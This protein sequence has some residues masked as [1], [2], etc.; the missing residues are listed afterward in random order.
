MVQSLFKTGVAAH[1]VG[2]PANTLRV[3]ERRYGLQCQQQDEHGHRLY[4]PEDVQRIAALRQLT[5]QGHAI[6]ALAGL[7]QEEL[8][9]LLSTQDEVREVAQALAQP[10]RPAR[11]L[12]LVGAA[13]ATRIRRAAPRRQLRI[14][15]TVDT[16]AQARLPEG[17]GR[18][19][20]LVLHLPSMHVTQVEELAA[21]ARA[22][23]VARV[24]AVYGYSNSQA[25]R[26]CTELDIQPWRDTHNDRSLVSWLQDSL[27]ATSPGPAAAR[28]SPAAPSPA[29]LLP[30]RIAPPQYDEAT[31][32][33]WAAR[34]TAVACE[35]PAHVAE[36]L[37]RLQQFEA[38]SADCEHRDDADRQLHEQLHHLAGTARM[39]FE[40]GLQLLADHEQALARPPAH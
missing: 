8:R 7:N 32:A 18:P 30:A 25:L 20:A 13:L 10:V 11:Q 3:W 14:T 23:G 6:G 38:Y 2:M 21:A 33:D 12:L 22:L 1:I 5:L 31:L 36:L 4:S 28:G 19:D 16:L 9:A 15:A 34:T 26:R 35:C 27:G 40:R 37:M 17:E 29:D 39:L 24:L